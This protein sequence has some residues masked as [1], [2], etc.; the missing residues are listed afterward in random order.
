MIDEH[1]IKEAIRI[2]EEYLKNLIYITEEEENI[3]KLISDLE[4]IGKDI[5]NTEG[6]SEK[7]YR[8]ALFEIEIMIR[9]ATEKIIP[10]HE[11]KK[12]LDKEQRKLYNSIKDKYPNITDDDM[13][14]YI[15]PYIVKIDEKY[16]KIYKHLL[17]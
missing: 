6:K 11:K 4:N 14:G 17:K 8:D 10:F 9:K 16:R 2:R 3:K 5:E 1:Y 13:K 7:Y 15:V 12:Q